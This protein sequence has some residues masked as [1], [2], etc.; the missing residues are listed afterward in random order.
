M[1]ETVKGAEERFL[2]CLDK[3]SVRHHLYSVWRDFV[4]MSACAISN[5]VDSHHFDQRE[6]M[7][8]DAM[9]KYDKDE[10]WLFP[11]MLAL[12]TRECYERPEQDFL[13]RIYMERG[14]NSSSDQVFTPFHVCQLAARVSLIHVLD[15]IDRDGYISIVDSCCG[16]GAFLIASVQVA[17]RRLVE[18]KIDPQDKILAIGRD[19]DE[20]VA[21]MCYIQLSVL[22]MTGYVEV[23]DAL[24]ESPV[25]CWYTPGYL[26]SAFNGDHH[27]SNNMRTEI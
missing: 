20:T 26:C 18:A 3:L 19:I 2:E 16:S 25:S 11:R 4:T 24:A 14:L 17:H 8:L 1:K 15:M 5:M 22:G 9:R 23:G 21:L 13:G 7:Y 27:Q 6:E 10:Q 12:L